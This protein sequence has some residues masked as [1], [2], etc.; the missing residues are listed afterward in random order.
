MLEKTGGKEA[1]RGHGGDQSKPR[2]TEMAYDEA[3]AMTNNTQYLI[4]KVM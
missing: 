1:V 2:V 3:M 4:V